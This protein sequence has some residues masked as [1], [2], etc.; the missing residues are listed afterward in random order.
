MRVARDELPGDDS[1]LRGASPLRELPPLRIQGAG[2]GFAGRSLVGSQ[3]WAA[4]GPCLP[5]AERMRLRRL[6]P[7]PWRSSCTGD[8]VSLTSCAPQEAPGGLAEPRGP[9]WSRFGPSFVP[10][11]LQRGAGAQRCEE[12]A[13]SPAEASSA[14][15]PARRASG[16]GVLGAGDPPGP[17]RRAGLLPLAGAEAQSP[18]L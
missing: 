15:V 16:L 1:Q 7:A 12:G 11:A 2:V 3:Q 14:P 8:E 5:A 10:A 4:V 13:L 6:V 17:E 18:G 9:L